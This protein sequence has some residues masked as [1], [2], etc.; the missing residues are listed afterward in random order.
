MNPPSITLTLRPKYNEQIRQLAKEQKIPLNKLI[1][2]IIIEYLDNKEKNI[3][4][5]QITKNFI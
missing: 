1:S 5:L 2:D 4:N 3:D